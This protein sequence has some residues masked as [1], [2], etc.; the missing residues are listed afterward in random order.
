MLANKKLGFTEN[1]AMPS[2]ATAESHAVTVLT[3]QSKDMGTATPSTDNDLETFSVSFDTDHSATTGSPVAAAS[4]AHSTA[5]DISA[6]SDSEAG[7]VSIAFSDSFT[8]GTDPR[9][10]L[11]ASLL[12]EVASLKQVISALTLKVDSHAQLLAPTERPL[13]SYSDVTMIQGPKRTKLVSTPVS[14]HP[15]SALKPPT[16]TLSKAEQALDQF[17]STQ[18]RRC[19]ST[20]PAPIGLRIVHID[21]YHHMRH[22]SPSLFGSILEV[23]FK[24]PKRFI[25]NVSIITER[26]VEVIIDASSLEQLKAALSAENCP[27]TLF[28]DL[29]VSVPLTDRITKDEAKP[30]FSKRIH[31]ELTRLRSSK[32]PLL[33][34]VAKLYASYS[35][36]INVRTLIPRSRPTPTYMSAFMPMDIDAPAEASTVSNSSAPMTS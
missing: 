28:T 14:F 25:I 33:L 16:A 20:A 23:K 10:A 2:P 18:L 30:I 7:S 1:N 26:L 9:D 4:I 27:L 29:D 17:S 8:V 5:M 6:T 31:K 11:I 32:Y 21:G 22:Q 24:F 12:K 35:E 3:T 19:F 34:R 15:T 36:D 13:A